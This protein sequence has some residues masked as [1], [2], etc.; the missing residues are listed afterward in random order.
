MFKSGFGLEEAEIRSFIPCLQA[1]S[2]ILLYKGSA[3]FPGSV[4]IE[5]NPIPPAVEHRW[6][7]QVGQPPHS[8]WLIPPV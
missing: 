8:D 5:S 2:I 7:R 3:S 6:S 4:T 1:I